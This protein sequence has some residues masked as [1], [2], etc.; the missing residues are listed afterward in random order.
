MKNVKWER[1]KF[2]N[3]R[4]IHTIWILRNN[5]ISAKIHRTKDGAL[6]NIFDN[7][8]HIAS[9]MGGTIASAKL[10]AEAILKY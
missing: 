3:D 1:S 5:S 6:L 2:E 10:M 8:T 4:G 7:G 9:Q